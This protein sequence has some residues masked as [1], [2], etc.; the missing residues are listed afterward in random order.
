MFP[1]VPKPF[2]TKGWNGKDA[3][4]NKDSK[5][6]F[7]VPTWQWTSIQRFPGSVVGKRETKNKGEDYPRTGNKVMEIHDD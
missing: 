6:G 3:P 7:I 5:F 1:I 2:T 4:M